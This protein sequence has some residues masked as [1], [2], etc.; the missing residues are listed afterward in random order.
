MPTDPFSPHCHLNYWKRDTQIVLFWMGQRGWGR[1]GGSGEGKRREM[2]ALELSS[3]NWNYFLCPQIMTF[4]SLS[5]WL[6]KTEMTMGNWKEKYSFIN[7]L[8]LKIQWLFKD[9]LKRFVCVFSSFM[10]HRIPWGFFVVVVMDK[11]HYIDFAHMINF[12]KE[13]ILSAC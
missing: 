7:T 11:T 2:K 13:I 12:T 5:E 9:L 4:P 6:Q 3:G 1:R 10:I 8:Q